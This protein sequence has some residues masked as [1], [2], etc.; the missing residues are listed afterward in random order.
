LRLL[1]DL[2]SA[3]D[4]T[5][6][7]FLR[8]GRRAGRLPHPSEVR[9]WLFRIATNYCLNELRSRNVRART[10]PQLVPLPGNP[11]EALAARN[12]AR[13]FLARLPPRARAVAL[14]TYVDGMRQQEVAA[15]LGVSRRTVVNC[16]TRVRESVAQSV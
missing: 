2:P 1:G 9:P 16:L 14:L 12:D 10:P 13:R 11:E 4:A 3:E 5:H 6:E 7:V 15:I 8:V